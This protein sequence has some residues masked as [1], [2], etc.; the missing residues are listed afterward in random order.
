MEIRHIACAVIT[1]KYKGSPRT[2]KSKVLLARREDYDN[3]E[4]PHC[5]V[6]G[7][8]EPKDISNR[9]IEALWDHYRLRIWVGAKI[10][11]V[12]ERVT[13]YKQD[14][15]QRSIEECDH[16]QGY[17]CGGQLAPANA[18]SAKYQKQWFTARELWDWH[19]SRLH[20]TTRQMI[21]DAF[22]I[23]ADPEHEHRRT[24]S[25][26]GSVTDGY[27]ISDDGR[28]IIFDDG[29]LH[30]EYIRTLVPKSQRE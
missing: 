28:S 7:D 6:P 26:A 20:C 22:A 1:E 29:I 2:G 12:H 9:L 17:L 10:G 18:P 13:M 5:T 15:N 8:I 21:Y 3:W 14:G 19:R 4:L 23:L 24:H 25:D 27:A 30:R 11:P 16:R